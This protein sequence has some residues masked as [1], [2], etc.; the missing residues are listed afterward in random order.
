MLAGAPQL[1]LV[2]ELEGDR[3]AGRVDIAAATDAGVTVVDTTNASSAPVAEWAL[4]LALLGLRQHGRFRDIISG[5]LMSYADYKTDPPGRELTGKRVG[6]IG[7]G[8]MAWRLVEL[9]RPFKVSVVE[10]DPYAPR[11]LANA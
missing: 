7:F 2:G 11:E 4:A 6:V 9:L 8:H 5:Q 3:R 10:Y 1:T